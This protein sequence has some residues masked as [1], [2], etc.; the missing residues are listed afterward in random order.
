M[1]KISR[2]LLIAGASSLFFAQAGL[3]EQNQ[4]VGSA[5]ITKDIDTVRT[6]AEISAKRDLIRRLL[7]TQIGADRLASVSE[8]TVD[9]M[10]QQIQASMIVD[11]QAEKNGNSYQVTIRAEIDA[12][13]F[14]RLMDDEGIKSSSDQAGANRQLIFVMLDETA[15]IGQDASKPTSVQTEYDRRTGASFSD[16]SVS[17]FSEKEKAASSSSQKSAASASGSSAAGFSNGYGSGAASQRARSS[18]ASSSKDASAYSRSTSAI[19]KAD[20]QAETHDDVRYRQTITYQAG[21]KKSGPAVATLAGLMG[22]FINYGFELADPTM[23]LNGYYKGTKLSFEQITAR[24]DFPAF[25]SY[26]ASLKAPYLMGGEISITDTGRQPGTNLFTCNGK[27]SVRAFPTAGGAAIGAGTETAN[28]AAQSYE[29]CEGQVSQALAKIVA[30]KVAPQINRHWRDQAQT[31]QDTIAAATKGGDFTLVIRAT[32]IDLGMQ[33]DIYDALGSTPGVSKQAMLDQSDTQMSFV[34]SYQGGVPLQLALFQKL[35]A[36][37]AY[38]QMKPK[39]EG[40]LIT[41]CVSGC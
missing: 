14:S 23:A 32:S 10:A 18:S 41:L 34:V 36:N 22:E 24:A 27:L 8:T 26:V 25:T 12:A 3:A 21:V 6:Q 9:S 35:R 33:A 7:K 29:D 1:K 16:Q 38:A 31:R 4:G 30:D 40:R 13:W 28:A 5:P 37:P 39:V 15:G 2:A 17:A 20:V 19:D 11:R